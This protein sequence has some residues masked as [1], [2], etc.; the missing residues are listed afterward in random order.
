MEALSQ[1]SY[2]PVRKTLYLNGIRSPAQTRRRL[3]VVPRVARIPEIGH[4]E[5][6]S[7]TDYSTARSAAASF[8]AMV[9]VLMGMRLA[10]NGLLINRY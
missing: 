2:G 4:L 8:S 5:S 10:A 3:P 1:L 7:R 6:D 9:R